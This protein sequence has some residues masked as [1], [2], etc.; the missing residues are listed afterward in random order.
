MKI[1]TIKVCFYLRYH[2]TY[3]Q[4]IW[5]YGNHPLLGSG[6][7]QKAQPLVYLNENYWK[8]DFIFPLTDQKIEYHYIL[9]DESGKEILE[10]GNDKFIDLKS[11]SVEQ[12]Q[13]I[14]TWND[15]GQIEN[16]FY[17]EPFEKILL[18][19]NISG[20]AAKKISKTSTHL[21]R[22]KAPLLQKG[23]TLALIGASPLLG[24]W[25]TQKTIPLTKVKDTP[26]FEV[27]LN[28]REAEF[29]LSYKYGIYDIKKKLFIN[30]ETGNNRIFTVPFQKNNF[31]YCNDGFA[32]F[33]DLYWK[34]AGVAIPVFSLRSKNCGGVGEFADIKLLVDWSKKI[35]LSLIQLLPINDTTA[36]HT[37][38][39]SYPYAAISAF[40]LHPLYIHIEALI[41]PT[42]KNLIQAYKK[43]KVKLNQLEAVDYVAVMQLKWKTLRTLFE[44]NGANDLASPNFNTFFSQNAHWLVPYSVFSYLRELYGTV[45]FNTWPTHS[46]YNELEIQ[47]LIRP[48]TSAYKEISFY[49]YVQFHLHTQLTKATQYANKKGIIVKGDIPIGVY[50]YGVDA[51]QHPEL[52][53]MDRQAGAPPDDFAIKGQNWGFPTYQWKKMAST[54]YHWWKQRFEQ[55]R[56]YFD[57]FRIDH[58]LGF[59]RIWSIPLHAL[60][61]IM[62]RFVPALPLKWQELIAKGITCDASRLT[63]PF[64]NENILWQLFGN[65]NDY[66]KQHFL[67]KVDNE[68][69]QFLPSFQSQVQVVNHFKTMPKEAWHQSIQDGLLHLLTNV[70]ILEDEIVGSYHFR[71]NIESTT[72]FQHLDE[73]TKTVLKELYNDYFFV[74]QNHLWEQEALAKLPHLKRAT[75]MLICGEDLGLVPACLPEVM[76]QL[77]ILSLEV[78][79]MPKASNTLFFNP[80]DAPYLSVVTPSSHDT[81]TIRGWWEEDP[82]KTQQFFNEVLAQKGEAPSECTPWINKAI[83]L[84]HLNAPAMWAIFQWQDFIGVDAAL[85][86]ND[87]QAERINDPS[88]ATHYWRYRMHLSLES[89]LKEKSF[90]DQWAMDI[91]E[92]GR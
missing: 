87:P 57:A 46:K 75:N 36:T 53:Y 8:T 18:K 30:F 26:F 71:F 2:T 14:D 51:W 66:V 52:F 48:T 19:E 47:K 40:A 65:D 28:L 61:G 90:N 3:G 55:M 67:T 22:V 44:A 78:Q 80:I 83:M 59:F 10:W 4:S 82:P 33:P 88:N 69:Y 63:Q 42:Q 17:K 39:D 21:F 92:S 70:I 20:V 5:I 58:I 35:G 62:G 23:Q 25:D 16:V 43:Q 41:T 77:G 76:K 32:A 12:L 84:Q 45:D 54:N 37:A 64:I 60:D 86:R 31:I 89:L 56:F 1:K 91:K 49:Y 38:T 15:E 9:R 73:T 85:R 79:R 29:P 24:A 74:K 72:S 11:I 50:R 34:G 13:C 81:S 68:L 27:A 7:P 6:D